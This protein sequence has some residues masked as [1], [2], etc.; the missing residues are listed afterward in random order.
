MLL[1]GW[2][3]ILTYI[4]VLVR[5]LKRDKHGGEARD[6][7]QEWAHNVWGFQRAKQNTKLMREVDLDTPTKFFSLLVLILS[8]TASWAAL[9]STRKSLYT[10]QPQKIRVHGVPEEYGI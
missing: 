5:K 1:I 4:F 7:I 6:R 3:F 2:K 10:A 8:V 9:S